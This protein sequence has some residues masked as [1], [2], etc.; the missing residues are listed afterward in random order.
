V[1]SSQRVRHRQRTA[2]VL[3]DP[4]TFA[5]ITVADGDPV[6]HIAAVRARE[7]PVDER[8]HW[9]TPSLHR[10]A[11]RFYERRAWSARSEE[12]NDKLQLTLTEYRLHLTCT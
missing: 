3:T 7:R 2:E 12:W 8:Q 6:G 9:Y 10:R 4:A 5:L 11:R 1:A